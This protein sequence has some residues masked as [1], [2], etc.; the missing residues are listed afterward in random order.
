MIVFSILRAVA[1][2]VWWWL[3]RLVLLIVGHLGWTAVAMII[4]GLCWVNETWWP[5][6]IIGALLLV[7]GVWAR[8]FPASFHRRVALPTFR[9]GRKRWVRRHWVATW[10]AC[11]MSRRTSGRD[12]K[13]LVHV[14]RRRRLHWANGVLSVQPV[15]LLGQTVADVETIADR[16][17]TAVGARR[18]RVIPDDSGT[19][20]TVLWSFDDPL[21]EPI[22]AAL[23]APDELPALD[24]VE[25]GWTEDEDRWRLPLISTLVAG[26]TGAGKASVMWSAIVALAPAIRSGL[27]EVHGIDLKGGMELTMGR[28]LFTRMATT[29]AQAVEVLE[30]VA[31]RLEI[32]ALALAG[33]VRDHRPTVAEPLVLVVIDELASLIAYSTDRDLTKR[34]EAGLSRILSAGRAP[35]FLIFAFL[36][37]PRKETVRMRHLFPQSLGLRLRDREEVTMVLGEGAVAAGAACHKIRRELPGTGYVAG[38]NGALVRVRADYVTDQLIGQ[39]SAM[40]PAP[41]Q[42]PTRSAPDPAA[43]AESGTPEQP[44][45]PRKSRRRL[46]PD[47]Q[48]E[49]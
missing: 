7:F 33:V 6:V 42:L 48:A 27:V 43:E 23:P 15:L 40:F 19:A 37:D 32:R 4:V 24:A 16:L 29:P 14:P 45:P 46:K 25:V 13:Q 30:D 9:R 34:A 38:D 20:C 22:T 11:G 36:Q 18:I 2:E 3:S 47:E 31:A 21:A 10:D 41:K 39:V 44:K 28:R 35:K 8:V 26:C 17:R 49:G 5:A 12:G 1:L